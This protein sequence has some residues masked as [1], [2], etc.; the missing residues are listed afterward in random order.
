MSEITQDT[1]CRIAGKR[2]W[3]PTGDNET[4][5]ERRGGLPA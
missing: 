1:R 2:A 5:Q 3:E 4:G